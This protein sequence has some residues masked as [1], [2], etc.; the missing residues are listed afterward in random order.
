M[1]TL[2]QLLAQ[3]EAGTLSPAELAELKQRLATP[4]ARAELISE[5]HLDEAI[6]DTLR[7]QPTEARAASKARVSQPAHWPARSQ[8]RLFPWLVWRQVHISLRWPLGFALASG[9]LL[10]GVYTVYDRSPVGKLTQVRAEVSIERDGK[11]LTAKLGQLLYPRD[12]VRVPSSGS[13]TLVWTGESTHLA[14]AGNTELQ[15]LNPMRG[16]RLALR[17][18]LLQAEVAAQPHWRPMIINTPVAQAKVVGTQ[19]SLST[20][21]AVSRLQVLEGAV[22]FR[23]TELTEVDVL[24]EVMVHA[25]EAAGVAPGVKLQVQYLTGFLSSDVW[26][27]PYG[28][29]L[30]DAPT[31]GTLLSQ[32][33]QSPVPGASHPVERLQGYLTAPATGDYT[34]Y[35]APFNADGAA[36]LLLSEDDQP[37][38]AHLIA[39]ASGQRN[40][41]PGPGV[42]AVSGA[43][44]RLDSAAAR[45]AAW[46]RSASQKSKPQR[47][48]EGRRYY[49]EAW[50]EGADIRSLLLGWV[51]PGQSEGAQ[52]RTIDLQTLSPFVQGATT[53]R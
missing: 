50:H 4:E 49:L 41:K 47:L 32:S 22:V 9:L 30:R 40:A 13:A 2:E 33:P 38:R 46:N 39:S 28:T 19:F 10:L 48:V 51:V 36:E 18:G 37:E 43:A 24:S 27:V 14:L 6:Y 16:K 11:K 12:L 29:H 45:R 15:V 35:I 25:G 53:T 17:T 5:W 3:W 42:D 31:H 8:R 34:F 26:A 21:G 52:P 1:K 7:S 44:R 23:K 20:T